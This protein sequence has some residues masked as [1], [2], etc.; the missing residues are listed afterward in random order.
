[1]LKTG[2]TMLLAGTALLA[3]W[4]SSGEERRATIRGGGGDSGKCTI[5]VEVDDVAEVEIRGDMGRLRTRSG[6]PATWRRFECT[7]VMPQNPGDFRFRGVDGRGRQELVN[8]PRGRGNAVIRITD[9]KGGREGYTF[10]LEWRGGSGGSGWG[11]SGGSGWGGSGNELRYSGTGSGYFSNASGLR[12]NLSNCRVYIDRNGNAE[13]S[14]RSSREGNVTL[15]GRV[16]RTSGDRVTASMSG[17][18]ISGNMDLYTNG[19]NRVREIR[20][21]GSNPVRFELRWRD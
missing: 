2:M 14:F 18:G 15:R 12:D 13:V 17:N 6:G 4:G 7:A 21:D 8:D 3:Q 20:M 1:M 9:S 19:P 10:D 16:N 11:G 5:E